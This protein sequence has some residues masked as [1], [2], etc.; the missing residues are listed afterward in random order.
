M[1]KNMM[2]RTEN[3][4]DSKKFAL[5]PIRSI[6]YLTTQRERTTHQ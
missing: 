2:D 6:M 5:I 4:M 1:A 3:K